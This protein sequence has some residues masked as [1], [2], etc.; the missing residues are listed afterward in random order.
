MR[1]GYR[2]DCAGPPPALHPYSLVADR[3]REELRRLTGDAPP[4]CPWRA[5]GDPL[6]AEVLELYRA[7]GGGTE[8]GAVPSRALALD[9]P[10]DAWQGLLHYAAVTTRIRIEDLRAQ[11]ER[12]ARRSAGPSRGDVAVSR[13][14]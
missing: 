7:C 1:A 3:T 10:H 12:E 5:F 6:I 11:R 13:R 2:C 14:G 4:S 8:G 9:P